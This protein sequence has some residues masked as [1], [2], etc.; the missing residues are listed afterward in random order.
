MQD[1]LLML[2]TPDTFDEEE[3]DDIV[4]SSRNIN[5]DTPTASVNTPTASVNEENVPEPSVIEEENNVDKENVAE[6]QEEQKKEEKNDYFSMKLAL[7]ERLR[8]AMLLIDKLP[9][10]NP[11]AQVHDYVKQVLESTDS[12][13]QPPNC[14]KFKTSRA[15]KHVPIRKLM[16]DF[17]EM[18][19][20]RYNR[21]KKK[22]KKLEGDLEANSVNGA[23]VEDIYLYAI[24]NAPLENPSGR[25]WTRKG[26]L[27]MLWLRILSYLLK[28]SYSNLALVLRHNKE[29]I[30][31]TIS[32][33]MI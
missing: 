30:K 5:K 24:K 3:S 21:K 23:T 33:C 11:H 7:K 22:E 18:G 19:K 14:D 32:L 25:E 17:K 9:D 12:W 6:Q 26:L 29:Q 27:Y 28:P 16:N 13:P 1:P 15:R 2:N 10:S 31:P 20:K 8:K 4:V